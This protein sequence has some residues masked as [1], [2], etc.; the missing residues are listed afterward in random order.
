MIDIRFNRHKL[1]EAR[2][3]KDMTQAMLAHELN[4]AQSTIADLERG[5]TSTISLERL[6]EISK[7]LDIPI[8]SLI[9]SDSS[10]VIF[11]KN[12][13]ACNHQY[14]EKFYTTESY[15][16]E[17]KFPEDSLPLHKRIHRIESILSDISDRLNKIE[18]G[19]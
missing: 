15:D 6:I 19:S 14:I 17:E 10:V 4:V 2:H 12:N 7:I 13:N 9:S 8:H 16:K 18:K 3:K 11:L 5:K 1:I